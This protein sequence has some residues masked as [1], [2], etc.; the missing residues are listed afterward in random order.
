MIA[1]NIGAL[2]A[3]CRR[4]LPAMLERR[5]GAIL[6][7]ASTAAFQAGPNSAVYYASKAYVL[8]LTEAL[9]HEAKGS[10]VRVTALCPGP[11][12]TEFFEV[13][14]S[15]DGTL[16]KLATDPADVVRAGLEGLA[17]GRAI[18]I[19]GFRNKLTAQANRVLPRATMRGIVAGLKK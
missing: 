18:V 3:L 12:A 11:T 6:N 16:A 5:R 13:A 9:H 14:G 4:V 8:S 17:R 7:V 19:P 15:A 10:G 1:L 2:T